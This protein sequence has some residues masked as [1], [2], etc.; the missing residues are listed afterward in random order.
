MRSVDLGSG[1]GLKPTHCLPTIYRSVPPGSTGVGGGEAQHI[2][3]QFFH[4]V[5][6]GGVERDMVNAENAR[7]RSGGLSVGADLEQDEG[8]GD[9]EVLHGGLDFSPIREAHGI[10]TRD[11]G[12]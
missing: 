9:A 6:R 8:E 3:V 5:G 10:K 2:A 1:A 12:A 11:Q 4:A 7:P